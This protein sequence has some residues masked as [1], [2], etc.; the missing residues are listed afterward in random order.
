METKFT[1]MICFCFLVF[2]PLH[3]ICAAD[4]ISEKEIE[5]RFAELTAHSL[6]S[7]SGNFIVFGTNRVENFA[8]G[9][10][11]ENAVK[12]IEHITGIKVPFNNRMVKLI[13]NAENRDV[14]GGA[15]VRYSQNGSKHTSRVYLENYDVAYHRRGR[16]A[17]CCAILAGYAKGSSKKTFLIPPWLWKGLEQNLLFDV[18]SSNMEFVLSSWKSGKLISVMEIIGHDNNSEINSQSEHIESPQ[19]LA[20]YSVFVHWLSSQ[21]NKKDIFRTLFSSGS[22]IT[23][24]GVQDLISGEDSGISLD[25]SWDRWLLQ[26]S[27]V[28]RSF[29]PISTHIIEKLQAELL[30]YPG[31]CGIP[32]ASEIPRGAGLVKLISFRDAEWL[33]Q[34]V[35]IKRSR[36]NLIAAGRSKDLAQVVNLFNEFISGLEKDRPDILLLGQLRT[37][38]SALSKLAEEVK[39][40]G[41]TLEE[42]GATELR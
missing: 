32:L 11:C 37:A 31:V 36:L 25:E 19:D 40:G 38:N 3:L 39:D 24:G 15:I 1:C 35:N 23:A 13:V 34:F 16:Q 10:W 8:L 33:P 18:R 41:G 28:V 4:D 21:S 29:T 17:I 14:P 22:Y 30:L 26:Q 2:L 27:R 5:D 20:V 9:D 12:Q 6:R 7:S 42:G